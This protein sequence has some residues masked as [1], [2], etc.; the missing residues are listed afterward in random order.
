MT[1]PNGEIEENFS[2][3]RFDVI[4]DDSDHHFVSS[5]LPKKNGRH[6]FANAS[7]GSPK[8]I[9]QEWKILEKHLP[10]SIFVRAYEN[11]IDLLRAVI[12]GATGTPYHDGLFFFDLAFPADYPARPPMVYYRSFGLRLNPNLYANG[13]VCLSLLNTWTG[14]KSEKWNPNE[15][16]VLQVLISI[17]A[18]VLN[19]KP[20]FNEPG[21]SMWPGRTIWEKKSTAYNEDVFVLSCKSMIFSLRKPPKNFEAFVSRHFRDRA[22]VILSACKN[23]MSGGVRVGYYRNDEPSFCSS[24]SD[25]IV[26][27]SEKFKGLILQLYPELVT[28]FAKTGASLGTLGEQ[29]KVERRTTS[30]KGEE[31]NKKK[32][33]K[34]TSGIAL[35]HKVF[36]KMKAALGLK[37]DGVKAR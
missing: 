36:G 29:L 31:L 14:K 18:L 17:Q 28:A 2:F 20:Y 37:K 27:A 6:P 10:E 19:E 11:R 7:G 5:N 15:S 34:T 26:D 23:Y 12:V 16:T 32:E 4:S 1:L 24:S 3:H 21:H 13:R 33:K 35:A 25:S 30:F 22:H 9:M 8:K